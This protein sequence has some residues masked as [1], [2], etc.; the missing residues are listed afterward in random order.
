MA[1]VALCLLSV[2]WQDAHARHIL[3]SDCLNLCHPIGRTDL[4]NHEKLLIQKLQQP[5]GLHAASEPVKVGNHDEQ[6]GHPRHLLGDGHIRAFQHG[7][8]HMRRHHVLE[9]AKNLLARLSLLE[10]LQEPKPRPTF[11]MKPTSYCHQD[12]RTKQQRP[13]GD[14]KH[15]VGMHAGGLPPGQSPAKMDAKYPQ[16]NEVKH[17][18]AGHKPRGQQDEEDLQLERRLTLQRAVRLTDCKP[19]TGADVLCAICFEDCTRPRGERW[20]A[21]RRD[22]EEREGEH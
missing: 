18:E 4:V 1:A 11:A 14:V 9:V 12:G 8:D 10:I 16:P 2:T 20:E 5:P 7:P 3:F 15:G 13:H 19:R 22:V 21:L 6:D 17:L